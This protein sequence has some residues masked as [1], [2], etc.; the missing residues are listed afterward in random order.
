MLRDDCLRSLWAFANLE[1]D[2]IGV[3]EPKTIL[4]QTSPVAG[5][6][7]HRGEALWNWLKVGDAL[8]L[9]R[10]P[11]NSYDRKAV[12]VEWQAASSVTLCARNHLV[13]QLL[14]RGKKLRARI[15]ALEKNVPPWE[16]IEFAIEIYE[17][18]VI[19]KKG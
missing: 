17:H 9:I 12:R 18:L 13:A 2:T 14:D 7:Y 1:P 10:E 11:E 15:V 19:E 8:E 16:R 4:L 6:Q 3:A 5:F